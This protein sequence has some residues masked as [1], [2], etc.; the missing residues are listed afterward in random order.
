VITRAV[1][2]ALAPSG[3]NASQFNVLIAISACDPATASA[4]AAHLA[5]DRTT[6]SRNLK[7]LL[8]AGL[9][10]SSG[11]AGRRARRL[12]LTPSGRVR[13]GEAIGL[14]QQVQGQLSRAIGVSQTGVL[15]ELLGRAASVG[16]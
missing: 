15:L 10:E 4:V 13:L 5:M 6:L 12:T 14:W 1:D 9:V 11:G 8:L 16:L 7:P 3:L 2:A